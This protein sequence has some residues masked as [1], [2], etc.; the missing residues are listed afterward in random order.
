MPY[1]RSIIALLPVIAGT[2]VVL[3]LLSSFL[4]LPT[5]THR[6]T[7]ADVAPTVIVLILAVALDVLGLLLYLWWVP[8]IPR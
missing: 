6:T 5:A 7:L 4:P 1:G 3:F 2:C 8:L